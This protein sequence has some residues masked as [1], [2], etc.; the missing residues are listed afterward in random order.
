MA[1]LNGSG[2][3][4]KEFD[5]LCQLMLN[6][7]QNMLQKY[8]MLVKD[9]SNS[10]Q[11]IDNLEKGMKLN[12]VDKLSFKSD[13]D[14]VKDIGV[15]K[16]DSLNV[17]DMPCGPS[18]LIQWDQATSVAWQDEEPGSREVGRRSRRE[19][20]STRR[21]SVKKYS[22]EKEDKDGE[23]GESIRLAK[24]F[25]GPTG[26][27]DLKLDEE[28]YDVTN[29]Y[30]K[31]GWAQNLARSGKFEKVTLAVIA[32]NAVYIGVDADRNTANTMLDAHWSFQTGD[33]L[34]CLFF[35]FEIVVRFLAFAEKKNTLKD[36][37]FVFDSILVTLMVAETWV[38]TLFLA[39]ISGPSSSLSLP[40]GPL[41]LLR[42]LRLS[43]LVRLLRA[44]PELLTLVN[45]I[46]AA[47]R[48]VTSSL[49][50]IVGINY[51]FSIIM[52]MFLGEVPE[53]S[54]YFNTLGNTMWTLG[55]D[56]TFMD[57]TRNVM[58]SLKGLDNFGYEWY[59][60][61][62]MIVVFFVYILLTNITVLN[63]LI[64]VLCEV[65]S[66]VKRQDDEKIAVDFMKQHLRGMLM[67]LDT[68]SNGQISKEEL[69]MLLDIPSAVTVLRQLEVE[70]EDLI[71][72]TETLYEQDARHGKVQ[73]VTREELMEV[74]LKIRGTREVTMQDIVE[75]R[76]DI[77][78]LLTRRFNEHD[79]MFRAMSATL[80]PTV[81]KEDLKPAAKTS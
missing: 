56:G 63:M 25:Y 71:E 55:M 26:N 8:E 80:V 46:G 23:S 16:L 7:M 49:M 38:L 70:P 36:A 35:T 67:V 53:L 34:F 33:N 28:L 66:V 18:P 21:E 39:I 77:R 52:N 72:L 79:A 43:R 47:N 68:D 73:E 1:K 57:S 54:E 74:I 6:D 3:L 37:W 32:I 50:L 58:D 41:R 61:W 59:L 24:G 75:L 2:E 30:K 51:V 64:G 44:L 15:S 14:T 48:A 4:P 13:I 27:S 69:Q 45:G 42:L 9:I 11:R 81:Q 29:F 5:S 10:K 17:P 19:R 22:E 31:E 12:T 65:I 76:C 20:K 62:G 78:R 60:G 40:T